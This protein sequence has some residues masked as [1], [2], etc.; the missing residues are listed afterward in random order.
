[1]KAVDTNIL[2]RFVLRDDEE[3]F[4][5]A[6]AFF[7][8]C[9]EREPGFVTAIVLMEFVWTL[10]AGYKFSHEEISSRLNALINSKE[11]LIEHVGEARKANELYAKREAEGFA[12]AFSGLIAL[13]Y[14][15][16]KTVTLDRK[17]ARLEFYEEL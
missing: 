1:M 16:E 9:S 4:Q 13:K 14:D 7:S 10:R 2:L 12:D 5:K 8:Q 15:C 3:Q 6:L 11:I 17:A